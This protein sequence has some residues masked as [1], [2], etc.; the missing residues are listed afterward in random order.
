[1]AFEAKGYAVH[2]WALPQGIAAQGSF[3][4]PALI[5]IERIDELEGEVFGPVLHV[6]RYPRA[7][8]EHLLARV[9]HTGYGLT[10][11]LHSRLDAT[12]AQVTAACRAGNLY[13]NRNTIGAVVGV[14]P[15]GGEGLSGTGPKAGGP[16]YLR[17]LLAKHPMDA[18]EVVLQ[19][20][21]ALH[22]TPGPAVQPALQALQRW[23]DTAMP[24]LAERCALYA[25]QS[26]AD[27]QVLL[28][29]PTGE[30]NSYRLVARPATLCLAATP[31]GP[32]WLLAAVLAVGGNA[33]WPAEH[34]ALHGRLPAAV[35]RHLVLASDWA[36]ALADNRLRVD[37][38]LHAGP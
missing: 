4:A 31:D 10:Q 25:A 36:Q 37:A 20:A 8:F 15:F 7:Q 1:A 11:G 18:R 35:T 29:G 14:Q 6:L 16:L 24:Q 32:L 28:P 30:H 17:R 27:L 13:I 34:A 3:V 9:N 2:Q 38:V 21:L 23:A 22:S 26:P 12:A 5:E 33:V 19:E